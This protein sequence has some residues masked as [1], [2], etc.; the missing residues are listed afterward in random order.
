MK[1]FSFEE[2]DPTDRRAGGKKGAKRRAQA[3]FTL[4]S[5]EHRSTIRFSSKVKEPSPARFS[6]AL[7]HTHALTHA[8]AH[9]HAHPHPHPHAHAPNNQTYNAEFLA[10]THER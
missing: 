4:Y 6:L 3:R 7:A 1:T 9:P 2:K 8:H 5:A 10:V